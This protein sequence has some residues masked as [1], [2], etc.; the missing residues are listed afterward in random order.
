MKK[1]LS[2]APR[3]LIWT[4]SAAGAVRTTFDGLCR[5]LVE[6][7]L[8]ITDFA[9]DRVCLK[10]KRGDMAVIGEGLCLAQAWQNAVIIEG[11][12]LSILLPEGGA[13]DV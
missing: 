3:E 1:K 12:I 10:T 11:R 2:R 7:H 13:G 8:G 4:E 9:P 5:V 6:N